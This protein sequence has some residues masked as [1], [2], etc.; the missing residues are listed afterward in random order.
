MGEGDLEQYF[1]QGYVTL[2]LSAR[3]MGQNVKNQ[4]QK[5]IDNEANNGI[6]C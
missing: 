6:W 2:G 5:D 1:I 3:Q 4:S